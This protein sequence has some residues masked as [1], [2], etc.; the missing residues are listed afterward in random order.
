MID[1]ALPESEY[2]QHPA[3]SSTQARKLL[4][5][6][7][8]YRW[9]RDHPQAAKKEFDLG[10]AVH[11]KVLGVGAPTVAFPDDLLAS[12][13]AASTKA[14]KEWIDEQRAAGR[15]P[16]KAAVAE[17]VDQMAEAVLAHP[18]ARALFEQPGNAEASVFATD[19]DTG[20]DMRARF[21]FLPELD[22]PRPMAVDLK[23]TGKRADKRAFEV[24]AHRMGYETQERWYAN[25][26]RLAADVDI[27]FL[28]VVVETEGPYLAA[29]HQLDAKFREMGDDK[30]RRALELYADCIATGNWGGYPQ[31]VQL[32]SPPAYAVYEHEEDFG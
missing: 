31:D 19:P 29:V 15:T 28:F 7:A 23:T 14:A 24:A 16:V 18:I 25:T 2:H 10:T 26:L 4:E 20:V 12:N 3:L 8:R 27:P 22:S 13:G 6:P 17:Q 30:T 32:C 9:D 5:S 11:S 1:L 21:D